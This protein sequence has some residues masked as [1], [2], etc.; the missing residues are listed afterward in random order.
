VLH[1]L[2]NS[3]AAIEP[4]DAAL[5]DRAV[6]VWVDSGRTRDAWLSLRQPGGADFSVLASTITSSLVTTAD[7]RANAMVRDKAVDD[8][9]AEYRRLAGFLESED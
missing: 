4:E 1:D 8:Q 6:K 7:Q 2:D 3:A 5:V 9:R